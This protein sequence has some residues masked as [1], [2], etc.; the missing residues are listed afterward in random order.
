MRKNRFQCRRESLK[1]R[2]LC[3]RCGD[4]KALPGRSIGILCEAELRLKN[5]VAPSAKRKAEKIGR[6]ERNLQFCVE[7]AKAITAQ[8]TAIRSE[9]VR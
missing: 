2:G 9:S 4:E 3:T 6:L 5:R 8:I 7:A 1:N